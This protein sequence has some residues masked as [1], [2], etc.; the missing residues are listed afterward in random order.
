MVILGTE[1]WRDPAMRTVATGVLV[2]GLF[3]AGC[4]GEEESALE[5]EW[6]LELNASCAFVATFEGNTYGNGAICALQDGGWGMEGEK[7]TF[8]ISGNQLTT[9]AHQASCQDADF[10]KVDTVGWK[11]E[12]DTLTISFPEG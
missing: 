9:T 1:T 6:A 5:G 8:T 12:G 10:K 11:R 7:G 3:G 4:G 2:L